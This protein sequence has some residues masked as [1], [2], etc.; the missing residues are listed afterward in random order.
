MVKRMKSNGGVRIAVYTTYRFM[1]KDPVIDE[2]RTLTQ[3]VAKRDGIKVANVQ[4]NAAKAANMSPST[5]EN[6]FKGPV[7]RPNNCSIEAYGRALGKKRT[8]TDL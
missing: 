6:W 8:W 5:P 7:K 2:L 1:N 3:Y 4:R